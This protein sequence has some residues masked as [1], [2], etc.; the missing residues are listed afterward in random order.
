[1]N[2]SPLKLLGAAGS[3]AFGTGGSGNATL[4]GRTGGLAGIA[5]LMMTASKNNNS[6]SNHE[7][8]MHQ[9]EQMDTTNFE[10]QRI[11]ELDQRILNPMET[12]MT[13]NIQPGAYNETGFSKGMVNNANQI[14]NTPEERNKII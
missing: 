13:G 1:M 8:T 2:K 9:G 3:A 7:A 11:N 4:T 12:T 6:I 5:N 10:A 14:F